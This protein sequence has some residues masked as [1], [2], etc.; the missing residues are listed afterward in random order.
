MPGGSTAAGVGPWNPT[1]GQTPEGPAPKVGEHTEAIAAFTTARELEPTDLN[2]IAG[3]AWALA[4]AG[5]RDSALAVVRDLP[6]EGEMLKDD[7]S[8]QNVVRLTKQIG[9]KRTEMA[10]MRIDHQFE[11]REI[12]TP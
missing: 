3:L 9:E 5:E 4:K 10:L 11:I 6:E 12:L 1:L 8:K 7:V 2:I